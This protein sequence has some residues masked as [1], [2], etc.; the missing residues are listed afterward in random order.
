M[1]TDVIF[2]AL[3]V[4][5]PAAATIT[6]KETKTKTITKCLTKIF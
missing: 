5:K 3:G 6:T 1:I 4:A 2:M